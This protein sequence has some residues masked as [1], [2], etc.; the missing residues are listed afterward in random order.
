M[1][2]RSPTIGCRYNGQVQRTLIVSSEQNLRF[3]T[4]SGN[5][6]SVPEPSGSSRSRSGH[7][8]KRL[9]PPKAALPLSGCASPLRM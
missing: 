1:L 6:L 3:G 2:R 8:H 9:V 7:P 5:D 4:S